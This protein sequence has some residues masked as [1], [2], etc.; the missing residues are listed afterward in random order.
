M[1]A[2]CEVKIFA[3][4]TELGEEQKIAERFTTTNTPEAVQYGYGTVLSTS[5]EAIALGQVAA[6]LIDVMY[7]KSIDNTMYVNPV[8]SSG[9]K[10]LKIASGESCVFHPNVS[11]AVL[12][13]GIICS[14]AGAKYEYLIVGQS[15]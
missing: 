5:M 6:S 14:T 10:V 13:V 3:N 12:S 11:N 7:V 2:Q 1:A 9:N 4:V 15:S 8:S